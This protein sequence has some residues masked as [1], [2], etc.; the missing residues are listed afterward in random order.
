MIPTV[1]PFTPTRAVNGTGIASSS[2]RSENESVI[3]NLQDWH[4]EPRPASARATKVDAV[5]YLR[6]EPAVTDQ[7][8][9]G[10]RIVSQIDDPIELIRRFTERFGPTNR[11]VFE[12]GTRTSNK[13]GK[14]F[15]EK[16]A[17]VFGHDPSDL[18]RTV[19]REVDEVIEKL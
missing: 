7:R 6:I 8:V 10:V 19:I 14:T 13:V 2:A 11:G 1:C 4:I 17:Q 3:A 16:P 18:A 12:H 15:I 5:L 9:R